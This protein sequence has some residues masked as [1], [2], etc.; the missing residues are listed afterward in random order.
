MHS[1]TKVI[2]HNMKEFVPGV[3][4]YINKWSETLFEVLVDNF[5]LTVCLRVVSEMKGT[6]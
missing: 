2:V 3:L 4:I 6:R 1:C 5:G